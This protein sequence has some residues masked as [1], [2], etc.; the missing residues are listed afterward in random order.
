[1][2]V[3]AGHNCDFVPCDKW[4]CDHLEEALFPLEAWGKDY[5]V[6]ASEPLRAE[7]NLV[8]VVSS[9]DGNSLTFDPASVHAAVTLNRGQS[10][11]F[12]ASQDFRVVGTEAFAV[13][14]HLVGQDYAGI[15]TGGMEG[16]GDPAFSLAIP[17][18]QFRTSY[19]FLAPLTYVISY[20]NVT[21]PSGA[22][23]TLDGAPVTGFREVGGTGFATA[24]V[25]ISGG[26]HHIEGGSP[27]GIVVY[28]F[29]SYTSYMYPGGL[30]FEAINI[31]F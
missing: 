13:V 17:T 23:V 28:G 19:D 22:T 14:Q 24:R 5:I 30:D 7:P 18:E 31:P 29:G 2:G 10:L 3:I 12:E 9:V 25:E 21:G 11:D 4:A 26:A 8:R 16:N 1:V 15:S 20:V 6:S 27:F